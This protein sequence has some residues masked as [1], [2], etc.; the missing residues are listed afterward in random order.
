MCRKLWI[1][2][3]C[4]RTALL[5]RRASSASAPAGAR[6]RNL[7]MLSQV[8][9]VDDHCTI[10]HDLGVYSLS[11]GGSVL[12]QQLV[13]APSQGKTS[14][15]P[16]QHQSSYPDERRCHQA[17]MLSAAERRWYTVLGSIGRG[18]VFDVGIGEV[19]EDDC[20]ISYHNHGM[21]GVLLMCLLWVNNN[22]LRLSTGL[23][24]RSTYICRRM[25]TASRL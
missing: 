8:F 11:S 18:D 9:N 12:T 4:N 3:A 1:T 14:S 13:G 17:S 24:F 22:Y 25:T 23:S 2:D 20:G 6:Q 5:Q 21:C 7:V 15:Y 16:H 10:R 19:D